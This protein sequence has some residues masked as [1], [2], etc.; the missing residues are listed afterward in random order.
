MRPGNPG[1]IQRMPGVTGAGRM[2]K[3]R[4]SAWAGDR[5]G[6]PPHRPDFDVVSVMVYRIYYAR[7][8]HEI[9]AAADHKRRVQLQ[10]ARTRPA[11][12]EPAWCEDH[13]PGPATV[14]GARRT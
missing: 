11:G 2:S 9:P 3:A 12:M 1:L 4:L 13:R 8:T 6:S 14:F 7:R 10:G 5:E